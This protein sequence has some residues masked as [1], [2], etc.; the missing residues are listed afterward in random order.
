[1]ERLD[2]MTAYCGLSCGSCPIH[3]ATFEQDK[4]LQQAMRETIAAQ[5]SKLYDMNLQSGDI[6]DC[7]GC[8]ADTGRIFQGCLNCGIRKCAMLKNIES[9]A[10]CI[11]YACEMLKKHFMLDPAAQLRIEEIR[12]TNSIL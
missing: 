2:K 12:Q 7:D 11:D 5:C 1:M 3:L 6:T 8:R 9:C 4:S 10:Y